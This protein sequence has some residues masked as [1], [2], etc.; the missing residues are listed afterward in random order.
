M[1][2]DSSLTTYPIFRLTVFLA[3]GIFL[4]DRLLSGVVSWICLLGCFLFFS[5]L[6]LAVLR[7]FSFGRRYL[8][9][10]MSGLAFFFLGAGL[11][12]AER[13]KV[14]FGWEDKAMLYWGKVKDVP[15]PRGKT[16]QAKV[17][18]VCQMN[19]FDTVCRPEKEPVGRSVL[20]SWMPDSA[21]RPIQCGDSIC[22]YAKISRPVSLE[23]LSGFDYGDYLMRQ[24][25]SG[26]GIAFSGDI[27]AF[28]ENQPAVSQR[29]LLVRQR[30]VGIYQEWGLEGDVLAVVSA[31][32]VGDRTRLTSDLEDVYSATGASHV[33]SLSG[34]HIAI[35]TGILFFLFRPL[36]RFKGGRSVSSVLIVL[37]LWV[38]AFV[39]GLSSPVIRSVI[40]FSLYIL[41]SLL[42]KDAYSGVFAVSLTAFVMLVFNPFYLFDISFQLSFVAVYSILLFYPLFSGLLK[43]GNSFCKYVWDVLALSMA[44]QLGTFPLI[45]LYFGAFPSYFL[46]A[47]LV[48]APLS[49]C[50]LGGT[51]AAL[52]LFSVPVIGTA[53][54]WLVDLSTSLLNLSMSEVRQLWGAQIT[55][56]H[57]SG[58]QVLLLYIILGL[59]YRIWAVTG[60][61]RGREVVV[62][63]SFSVL[64]L[65]TCLYEVSRPSVCYLCFARSGVYTKCGNTLTLQQTADGVFNIRGVR[66]GVMKSDMWQNKTSDIRLSLDYV[67]ICRGFKGSVSMLARMFDIRSVV[68][69]SSLSEY[70]RNRLI[71][72]CQLLKISYT[73]LSKEGSCLILL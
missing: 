22:F 15:Y 29:A 20:L 41:S 61:K 53:A 70:L 40:M 17:D 52:L 35:L 10:C 31:L 36:K 71:R 8:F 27:R 37:F 63:L 64:F 51:L 48:V 28:G 34:L 9:G 24:G 55:S 44:A 47:N 65:L 68:L 5:V 69:D 26:A 50:I 4:S 42:S 66:V 59:F 33:L 1:R 14:K 54:I 72:E 23:K 11:V 13:E 62:T 46:L 19:P 21:S 39:S 57:V 73:D 12:L 25:I 3:A 60:L 49:V 67:Y 18:V 58:L 56:L 30:I 16:M 6:S 38:F 32:T 2:I 45:L 7:T 43:A